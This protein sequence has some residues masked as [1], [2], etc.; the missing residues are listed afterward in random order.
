MQELGYINNS[1]YNE[2]IQNVDNGL[3]FKN[4]DVEPE[5]MVYISYHTDALITE[6]TNDIEDK[7]NISETFATNYINMAGLTIHSTQDSNIQSETE[8][9]CEKSK[10]VLKSQIGGDSSQAAMVV[11]DH[12]TGQVL[13]CVGALGKKTESRPFNRATQSVRQTGSSI[14]PIAVLA[15]AN[16]QKDNHSFISI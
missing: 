10:Y 15:P 11:M 5:S 14:K 9:E 12:S 2:A 13:A 16:R 6:I 7:Y 4:G 8:K 1:E 3:K